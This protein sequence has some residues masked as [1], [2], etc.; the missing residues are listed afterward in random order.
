MYIFVN[1]GLGMSSGK[2]AAQAAHAA[3]EAYRASEA[4]EEFELIDAWVSG[5]HYTKIVLGADDS[6]QLLTIDRYLTDRGFDTSLIIDEGRTEIEPMSPTALGVEIVDKDDP[7]VSDTFSHF[8]LYKDAEPS[9]PEPSEGSGAKADTNRIVLGPED[10]VKFVVD[11]GETA[12]KIARTLRDFK[13]M[14]GSD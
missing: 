10:V 14:L 11:N 6:T 9:D 7:H 5:G 8:K 12:Q 4:L 13:N 2:I 1:R 3:V